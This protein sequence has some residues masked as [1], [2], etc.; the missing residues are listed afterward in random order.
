[1]TIDLLSFLFGVLTALAVVIVFERFWGKFF[2]N[3]RIR[4]L[5]RQMARLRQTLKKK[6]DL[7]VKS[8]K[9]LEKENKDEQSD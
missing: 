1:M 7:I 4:E 6:D 2:G 9:S 3:R 8:L 5:E